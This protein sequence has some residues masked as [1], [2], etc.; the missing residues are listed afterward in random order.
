GRA[1]EGDL[2]LFED[3]GEAGVLGQETVARMHGLGARD[4]AGGQ[5]RGNVE[6]AVA[7]GVRPDADALVG[8]AHVHGIGVRERVD[9]NGLDAQFLAGAQD[10]QGDFAAIGDQNLGEHA[11]PAFV[12]SMTRRGSPYSTGE[13][14]ETRMRVTLPDLCA[15]I[16]FMVFIASTMRTV[17]PSE[18]LA[19]TSMKGLAPGSGAR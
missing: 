6:I 13:A 15:G 2:V 8:E 10:A 14:S 3:A 12:Y 9:G 1:D 4:L 17:S 19:P 7:R 5:D 18:T 16:W 11:L